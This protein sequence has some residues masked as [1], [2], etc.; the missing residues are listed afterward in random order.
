[1]KF[2]IIILSCFCFH[3]YIFPQRSFFCDLHWFVKIL[4]LLHTLLLQ[5]V[6]HLQ[7]LYNISKGDSVS[8]LWQ[9]ALPVRRPAPSHQHR[10]TAQIPSGGP[11]QGGGGSGW[12]GG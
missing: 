2:I 10:Q 4:L 5:G 11:V 12:L 7:F 3:T 1:M 9:Q 8:S 6:A